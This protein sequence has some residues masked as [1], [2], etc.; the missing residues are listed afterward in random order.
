MHGCCRHHSIDRA[1]IARR[2]YG[3]RDQDRRS[4]PPDR[5]RGRRPAASCVRAP[6]WRST[7]PTTPCPT[8][9]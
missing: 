9:T 3:R 5:R 4:V 6:S 2:G 7:S 8:S 1:G